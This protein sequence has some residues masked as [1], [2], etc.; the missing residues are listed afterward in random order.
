MAAYTGDA[1]QEGVHALPLLKYMKSDSDDNRKGLLAW[2]LEMAGPIKAAIDAG[3]PIHKLA[4]HIKSYKDT[5][6]FMAAFNDETFGRCKDMFKVGPK[7]WRQVP[8]LRAKWYSEGG[9]GDG[10]HGEG[11]LNQEQVK[12][13]MD[14]LSELGYDKDRKPEQVQEIKRGLTK[15][16]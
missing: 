14:A 2:A 9:A 13:V 7:C 1:L 5:E 6:A 16:L 4:A 10:R 3:H 11:G 8:E 12:A 15:A